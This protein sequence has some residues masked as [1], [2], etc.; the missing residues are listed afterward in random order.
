MAAPAAHKGTRAWPAAAGRW[1]ARVTRSFGRAEKYDAHTALQA[2]VARRL[3]GLLL[4]RLGATPPEVLEIGCG[5]GHLSRFLLESLPDAKLLLTDVAEPMVRRCRQKLEGFSERV[6]FAVLDGEAAQDDGMWDAIVSS[7]AFQ[8]FACLPEAIGR[9]ASRV[10]PGGVL[11]FSLPVEGSLAE[12]DALLAAHGGARETSFF[13]GGAG[14]RD[15]FRAMDGW[16]F[17]VLEESVAGEYQDLRSFLLAIKLSGA[18]TS[19]AGHDAIPIG[20][21]RRLLHVTRGKPFR[22]TWKIL[23]ALGV[24]E[25]G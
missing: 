18:G 16:S 8:W 17:N 2:A 4:M 10:K 15:Q 7:M 19:R 9:L 25:R 20:V 3:H 5:T 6:S 1:K 13:A 23:Y 14:L 22:A 12:W 11:A 24:K 21:F